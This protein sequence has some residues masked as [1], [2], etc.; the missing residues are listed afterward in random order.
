MFH[1]CFKR[2]SMRYVIDSCVSFFYLIYHKGSFTVSHTI[3]LR[4]GV[5]LTSSFLIRPVFHIRFF[6][7]CRTTKLELVFVVDGSSSV[8]REDFGLAKQWIHNM[9]QNFDISPYTTRV[10][11]VQYRLV[12]LHQFLM[13]Y[14]RGKFFISSSL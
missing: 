2:F 7:G 6:A 3:L 10:A 11:V 5:N 8:S 12:E 13:I 9:T 14:N 4:P 1:N